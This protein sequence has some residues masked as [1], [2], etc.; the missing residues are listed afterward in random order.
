MTGPR[1][2]NYSMRTFDEKF[3]RYNK[4]TQ[5]RFCTC[6]YCNQFEYCKPCENL[7]FYG[8]CF[9]GKDCGITAVGDF[10]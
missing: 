9:K 1:A 8:N 10:Y 5:C 2:T 3:T 7:M 6:P 4:D